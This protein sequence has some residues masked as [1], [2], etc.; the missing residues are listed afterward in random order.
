MGCLPDARDGAHLSHGPTGHKR[1]RQ[2][3]YVTRRLEP[4]DNRISPPGNRGPA[5]LPLCT[6]R[7]QLCANHPQIVAVPWLEAV[8]KS[9]PLRGASQTLEPPCRSLLASAS[10]LA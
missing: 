9:G 3:L 1:P 10:C 6:H 7:Y 5:M 2:A 4:V 8:G